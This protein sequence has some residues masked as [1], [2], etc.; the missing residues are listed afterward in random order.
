MERH[1]VLLQ[2]RGE[3]QRARAR[4]D[5]FLRLPGLRHAL[6]LQSLGPQL[7]R[8]RLGRLLLARLWRPVKRR[9][10]GP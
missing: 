7:Y 6:A 10:L 8:S 5:R 3:L 2:E 1:R 9:L 4:V